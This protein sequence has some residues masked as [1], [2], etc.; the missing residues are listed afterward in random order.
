M[1]QHIEEN[2]RVASLLRAYNDGIDG[3][4][5]TLLRVEKSWVETERRSTLRTEYRKKKKICKDILK[6][7]HPD[8]VRAIIG[9][10][11]FSVQ[12]SKL[13][14]PNRGF[15]LW[16]IYGMFH[17]SGLTNLPPTPAEYDEVITKIMDVYIREHSNL[18]GP[19]KNNKIIEMVHEWAYKPK[20]QNRPVGS[21]DSQISD[22]DIVQYQEWRWGIM[23]RIKPLR[24][25]AKWDKPL[26]RP[27]VLIG[28]SCRI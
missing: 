3:F 4:F 7:I 5:D 20:S 11:I 6:H 14:P 12:R 22:T 24:Q 8:I 18:D 16:V 15:F 1:S 10:N 27:L 17:M 2:D 25:A 13:P 26:S 23:E 9:G 21:I 19:T 28:Q